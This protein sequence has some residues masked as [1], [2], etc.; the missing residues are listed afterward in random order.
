MKGRNGKERVW[1]P[2]RCCGNAVLNLNVKR[3]DYNATC[4]CQGK[5]KETIETITASHVN[6]LICWFGCAGLL[7]LLEADS[8]PSHAPSYVALEMETSTCSNL[9]YMSSLT[10]CNSLFRPHLTYHLKLK[11]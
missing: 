6:L 5:T 3:N 8:T 11:L 10:C 9:M 4:N 1:E 7:V 2:A